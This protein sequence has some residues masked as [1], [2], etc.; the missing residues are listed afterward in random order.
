M[1]ATETATFRDAD[2][3][4]RRAA[5]ML[6]RRSAR[7]YRVRLGRAIADMIGNGPLS[8]LP[9]ID[10]LEF[11]HWT[12]V[13]QARMDGEL[14]TAIIRCGAA[15][16]VKLRESNEEVRK[17]AK[18]R[19]GFSVDFYLSRTPRISC[20]E[21]SGRR[22]AWRAK[23]STTWT[24][25][26][27]DATP[28]PRFSPTWNFTRSGQLHGVTPVRRTRQNTRRLAYRGSHG[29]HA[30]AVALYQTRGARI[31]G[32]RARRRTAEQLAATLVGRTAAKQGSWRAMYLD[33]FTGDALT[34]A[35]A[36]ADTVL[37]D[38]DAIRMFERRGGG[39]GR[40][41]LAGE[42]SAYEEEWPDADEIRKKRLKEMRENQPIT[43]RLF[44]MRN[45]ALQMAQS[46]PRTRRD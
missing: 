9:G 21:W 1:R 36:M 6:R 4:R 38:T 20:D 40:R 5:H 11:E 46:D 43:E 42:E 28:P 35:A 32:R 17:R 8:K 12:R 14:R 29:V 44:A 33:G 22:I 31:R 39:G 24:R 27:A 18:G 34:A 41:R 15:L 26:A 10:D 19:F 23:S 16:E 30:H 2:E 3:A 25:R 7:R 13:M 45:A 37:E